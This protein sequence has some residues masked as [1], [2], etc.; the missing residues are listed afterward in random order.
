MAFIGVH[1]S[2]ELKAR[3][4]ALAQSEGGQS[5]LLRRL[6][7]TVTEQAPDTVRPLA[8]GVSDKVTVRFRRSER[9]AITDAAAAR[10]MTRTGWI[11]SLVRARLGLG[12]PLN[13]GEEEAL[14]AI[15]R[16][17]HR[18]GGS[19]NQIARAANLAAQTGQPVTFDPAVLEEA[20]G[21][22]VEATGELR[23][24][25]ARSAGSWKVPV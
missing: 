17:L 18:I 10:G 12:L 1:V 5:A 21:V 14:R 19:I 4:A 24:V 9:A 7:S 6:V 11:A 25:L 23:H 3:F 20:R 2:E 15:A 16:E 22:V 13:G 8:T